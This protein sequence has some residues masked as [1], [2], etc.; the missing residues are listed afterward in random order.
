MLFRSGDKMSLLLDA[1]L[2]TATDNCGNIATKT[3]EVSLVR[4]ITDKMTIGSNCNSGFLKYDV[5]EMYGVDGYVRVSVFNKKTNSYTTQKRKAVD[6]FSNLSPG[7]YY[8]RVWYLYH[9][10]TN[11]NL[12]RA[13]IQ[14][15]IR[16]DKNTFSVYEHEVRRD[17]KVEPQKS[18]SSEH[19]VAACSASSNSGL[20]SEIGRAHV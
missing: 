3:I 14:S 16:N 2:L 10:T 19:S 8:L 12:V 17:F 18:M 11:N 1:Y 9:Q 5:G 6:V 4:K 13:T 20:I 7:D 15:A